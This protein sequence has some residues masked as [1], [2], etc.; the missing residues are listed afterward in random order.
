M[1]GPG[2]D[3][4]FMRV[5]S[6]DRARRVACHVCGVAEDQYCNDRWG[7]STSFVHEA[8]LIEAGEPTNH[9]ALP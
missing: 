2:L 3:R 1:P 8:R 7:R 5:K 9:Y 4:Y 6:Q